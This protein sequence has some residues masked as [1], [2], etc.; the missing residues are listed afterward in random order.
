MW[1]LVLVQQL[2]DKQFC[3]SEIPLTFIFIPYFLYFRD[4]VYSSHEEAIPTVTTSFISEWKFSRSCLS[5]F[6]FSYFGQKD[7][8]YSY[9][10]SG[11]TR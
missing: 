9:E 1:K 8:T 6:Y 3:V 4:Q 11:E 2:V 5:E 7:G 10:S